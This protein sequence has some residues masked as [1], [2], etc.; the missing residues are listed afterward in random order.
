M[1]NITK[2]QNML[3]LLRAGCLLLAVTFLLGA[4]GCKDT[5]S[6]QYASEKRAALAKDDL[7]KKKEEATSL[8]DTERVAA[9]LEQLVVQYPDSAECKEWRLQLANLYLTLGS[10]EPAYR[11]YKDYTKLYPNDSNT[12]EAGFQA[13]YAKY[14]Q[15]VRMRK[16]CDI[17]E[18]KKTI[19]LCQKYLA[20]PNHVTRRTEAEDIMKTCENRIFNKEVYVVET[21]LAY[22]KMQS[23]KTRLESLKEIYLPHNAQLE[24]QLMYL[25][26][27]VA[28]ADNRPDDVRQIYTDLQSKFPESPFVKMAQTQI[29]AFA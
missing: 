22:G 12:E 1:M 13:L 3:F 4:S 19:E 18:A 23:A 21:N 29:K 25:E 7:L 14:K 24:P 11:V 20:N 15:T 26:C 5:K 17:S 27:K 8:H 10:L 16:E 6:T 9:C 2:E 28:R